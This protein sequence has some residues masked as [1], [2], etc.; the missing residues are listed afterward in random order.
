[1]LDKLIKMQES[2]AG[3]TMNRWDYVH[4]AAQT[5]GVKADKIVEV[6]VFRGEMSHNLRRLFPDAELYLIDPWLRHDEYNTG[7]AGN[8][9]SRTGIKKQ[10]GYDKIYDDV[11][12]MFEGDS[13]THVIRGFSKEVSSLIPDDLDIV[14]IDANHAYEHVKDD[15]NIWL[16][17]VK[18]NGLLCGH[19]Y[20]CWS[21]VTQAVSEM[22]NYVASGRNKG[23]V[24]VSPK[25]DPR[26]EGDNVVV[27][28][29][30]GEV[31]QNLAR[32]LVN[33]LRAFGYDEDIIVF[34]DKKVDIDGAIVDPIIGTDR[35]E[36]IRN[37]QDRKIFRNTTDDH[38]F[39]YIMAR[40]C[41]DLFM[42]V[43]KYRYIM[44]LDCDVLA[45]G[46]IKPLFY[47]DE[48]RVL[49]IGQKRRTLM[50]GCGEHLFDKLSANDQ[51]AAKKRIKSNAGVIGIPSHMASK[52]FSEWRN[53]YKQYVGKDIIVDGG[54]QLNDEHILNYMIA[55][56]DFE[57]VHDERVGYNKRRNGKLLYHFIGKVSKS[58]AE[59]TEFYNQY[60]EDHLLR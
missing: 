2:L 39:D 60:V 6:G 5:A 53:L 51:N 38:E 45:A 29:A 56:G 28:I 3:K 8:A 43:S 37:K 35:Q 23:D 13:K 49:C 7:P 58:Q 18:K 9:Y 24:W 30:F 57:R 15:I 47:R 17:K 26:Y 31:Y 22:L 12:A 41:I 19:D 44:Y 21:G 55:R 16:P 52:I 34:T 46:N 50:G 11:C 32:M 20:R 27:L 33:S 40:T 48:E 4:L 59:Q 42:D 10:N 14:F 36:Y 25:V 1:M 54:K